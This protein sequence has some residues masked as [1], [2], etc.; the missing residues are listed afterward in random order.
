MPENTIPRLDRVR[1]CLLGGAVGD[2]LGAPVEFLSLA[3]IRAQ[4]GPKG[5]G[6]FVPAYGVL[7]AITDDT[8][9]T[10]FTAEALLRARSAAQH[11]RCYPPTILRNAY[12]RWLMTQEMRAPEPQPHDPH[13]G[14]LLDEQALYATRA[15]GVTCLSALRSNK[16]GTVED[17]IND[18]K[19]CGGIMRAAP[20]GLFTHDD[21]FRLGCEAAAVT[22][23]HPTGH[24]AAGYFAVII[25]AL[26]HGTT[27]REA[28]AAATRRV[29]YVDG[30]SETI[31]HVQGAMGRAEE[32]LRA[33]LPAT[34]D[35]VERLGGGWVAEQALAIG[36]FCAMMHEAPTTAA[37]EQ[38]L[39]L[40]VNHG[41]DS[42]STGLIAGQLL[43][44][45]HGAAVIPERWLAQV[46]L[47]DVLERTAADVATQYRD[48]PEWR[49]MYPPV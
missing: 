18:S 16:F 46:E 35:D 21:A 27:L 10:L 11:H 9:M 33:G 39:R 28:I 20:A 12:L 17:R 4:F 23:G 13:R 19:G 42:D 8:Q 49:A 45:M 5:I 40:A 41:G 26:L 3:Q 30:R 22:H 36:V 2:A 31:N 25:H 1:G 32:L 48:D 24:V 34:A 43:G 7:G 38:A 47:R 15:P 14:W 44:T 37:F 29:Q 6:D